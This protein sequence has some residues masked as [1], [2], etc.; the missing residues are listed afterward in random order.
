MTVSGQ[1]IKT[2]PAPL[3]CRA[4]NGH[5]VTEVAPSQLA[6]AWLDAPRTHRLPFLTDP[7]A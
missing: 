7:P 3:M 4:E 6:P 5:A 2:R 1:T